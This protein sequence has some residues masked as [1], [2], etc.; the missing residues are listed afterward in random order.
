MKT[1]RHIIA[2]AALI[3]TVILISGCASR[4]FVRNELGTLQTQVAEIQDQY[5]QE[6]E[7]IDA[8]DRRAADAARAANGALMAATAAGDFA[9]AATRTAATAERRA[10]AAQQATQ[11]AAARI[12]MVE[13]RLGGRIANLDKYRV[14]DQQTVVFAFDSAEL[15]SEA[16]SKLNNLAAAISADD[17]GYMIELQGFT[18]NVGAERYNVGLSA[19][20]AESVMRYLLGKNVPLYRISIIGLGETSPVGDNKTAAGREQN[21]RVQVRVL[22]SAGTVTTATR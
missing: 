21:R 6:S 12:D 14:A 4:H 1:Q 17:A 7:R 16:L 22:R 20:R 10:D 18:D 15:P 2:F 13:E 9:I 19:R 11:R 5:S 8:V 3:L